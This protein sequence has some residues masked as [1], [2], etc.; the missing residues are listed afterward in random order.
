V[1]ENLTIII[2]T[3]NEELRIERCLDSLVGICENIF[4][5]DSQSTDKTTEI[6]DDRGIK[7][8]QHEF[9]TYSEKRNWSQNNNPFN[10]EWVMHLD[11][12]EPITHELAS[13]LVN[14]FP[15][16]CKKYDG[17]MF[18]RR[19]YFLGRWMKHGMQYPIFHLRLY[20]ASLG[21]CEEKAY[22][23]H[24]VIQSE[25]V[26]SI[27]G[28]DIHNVV[29]ESLSDFIV[30]HDKWSTLE[31]K[32]ISEG[33]KKGDVVAKLFGNPIER[34][35]WFKA[36]VFEKSPM[37]L[38]G[39]ALFFYRYFIRLGFLDGKEGLIYHVLQ[40]FWFRFLIDAKVYECTKN[41]K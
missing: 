14:D 1:L 19:A 18:S 20:K 23:S 39:F 6:L 11:A 26:K 3:Y 12:D 5:V 38:R 32:E 15:I 22:D 25:N 30:S 7:H 28:A 10:T 13:W 37:F 24:F 8:T 2:V 9:I 4:V 34:R 36:N 27:N 29:A 33:G 40:A 35:R 21:M 31:A 41:K 16:A 17:F